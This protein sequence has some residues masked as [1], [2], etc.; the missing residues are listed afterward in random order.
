[1]TEPTPIDAYE[2]F[3][4]TAP[5]SKGGNYT[6][7]VYRRGAGP[8]VMVMQELPGIGREALAFADRLVDAGYQVVLPHWFGPIGRTSMLGNTVRLLC[9]R[10]VFSL[11]AKDH[12]SPVIGWLMALCR[13]LKDESGYPGV[14]V[15]GMCLSGNF[16]LSLLA[17][18]SVLA[19]VASQPSL[20]IGGHDALHM[21]PEDVAA[22]RTRLD[23]IGP[24]QAYRF[25]EDPL[26]R[27]AKYEAFDAAFNTD[28]AERLT[29]TTLPG[30]GHSVFT[31]HFVDEAGH[32]THAAL[33][34]V[35]GYFGR[36]LKAAGD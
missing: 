22:I 9:M 8:A 36:R 27:A 32:P 23:T 19:A 33:Q 21:A 28:G 24:A 14:G 6:A 2:R 30:P 35:L 7:P 16:A 17:D 10:R 11:F 4:F 5:L 3:A 12:S 31:L 25:A 20:P 29:L 1:M 18:D 15:V 34:S 26:C 13:R